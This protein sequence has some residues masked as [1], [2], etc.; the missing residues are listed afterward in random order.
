MLVHHRQARPLGLDAPGEP[1]RLKRLAA[2]AA[3]VKAHLETGIGFGHRGAMDARGLRIATVQHEIMDAQIDGCGARRAK[4]GAAR[5]DNGQ[6]MARRGAGHQAFQIN[7]R[8]R[9]ISP[10]GRR[11]ISFISAKYSPTSKCLGPSAFG[12]ICDRCIAW[13]RP[14]ARR[15]S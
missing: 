2:R 15:A 3:F 5:Q 1:Q 8:R 11:N 6:G 7:R 14:K 12:T 9:M 10:I 13:A 4:R